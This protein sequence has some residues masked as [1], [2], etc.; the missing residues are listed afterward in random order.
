MKIIVSL[1]CFGLAL[2]FA[3]SVV[4][5]TRH[6]PVEGTIRTSDLGKNYFHFMVIPYA[7]PAVGALKFRVRLKTLEDQSIASSIES[8]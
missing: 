1:V 4:V 2:E 5:Q 6:G 7:R 8:C 3:D